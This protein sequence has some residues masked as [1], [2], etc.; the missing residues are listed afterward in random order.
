MESLQDEA[1][2]SQ[3]KLSLLIKLS[4]TVLGMTSIVHSVEVGSRNNL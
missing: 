1:A 4:N 3:I 2:N